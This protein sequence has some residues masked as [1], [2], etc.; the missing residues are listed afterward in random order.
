MHEITA[1]AIEDLFQGRLKDY[2][3]EL[4]HHYSLSGNVPKAVEYLH[5]AGQQAL[6]R[7]A[8]VEAI[9]HLSTAIE[10]LKRQPDTAE[11]ARQELTLLLTLGPALMATRGQASQEVEANYRRALALCEQGRQTPYVFSAQ[12]GLWAF[13]QLRAQYQVAL[14]LGKRCSA[15]RCSRSAPSNWPKAIACWA[16]RCSGW[17]SSTPRARIWRPCSPCPTPTRRPMTS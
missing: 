15:W 3:S 11:R 4:A 13:Y 14:P 2:C 8:Q 9:R 17:A 16:P 7:S 10:L 6:Q 1:R 12:L 5:C